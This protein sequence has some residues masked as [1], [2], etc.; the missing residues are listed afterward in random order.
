MAMNATLAPWNARISAG[1]VIEALT[2]MWLD[3]PTEMTL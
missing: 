2:F 1:A 3:K